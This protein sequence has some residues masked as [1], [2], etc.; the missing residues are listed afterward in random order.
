MSPIST[1]RSVPRFDSITGSV[2]AVL[3]AVYG[4]SL[5][6]PAAGVQWSPI[7]YSV[8]AL[9]FYLA[10]VALAA[11]DEHR[12]R[13]SGIPAATAYWAL[14]GTL[15]YLAARTRVLVSHDRAGLA[16]LWIAIAAFFATATGLALLA[17]V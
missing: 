6:L 8:I 9:A 5:V 3:P 12:L 2:L 16:L 14:L 13:A 10:S 17:L 15:P 1:T 4:A 11:I 7:E